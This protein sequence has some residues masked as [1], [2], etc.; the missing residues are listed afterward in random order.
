M[1]EEE[2]K[3]EDE[4]LSEWEQMAENDE[5]AAPEGEAAAEEGAAER[6]LDQDEIDSLLGGS[7]GDSGPV[8]GIK[9][10]VDTNVVNYEKL[11]MLEVIFDK[12]ERYL[13]TSLRHFT[14]DNVDVTITSMTSVRFG[15]YLNSVPL[16]AGLLVVKAHGLDDYI[17]MVY[18]SKLI[19]AVVDILL[20]GRK[21]RPARVEGRN[22]TTIERRIMDNLS[23]VVLKDLSQAFT[24]VSP[25]KFTPERMEVNPRFAV[26]TRDGNAAILITVKVTLEEREGLMHFCLP[27]AT[28]EPIRD[29]L[30]QQFMGEKFG[31][32][33][34]WENHL[35]EELY[36]TTVDVSA[37]MGEMT[38][39]LS[40]VLEWRLGDTIQLNAREDSPVRLECGTVTKMIGKM[41]KLHDHK[42]VQILRTISDVNNEQKS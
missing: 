16:P 8:T 30:L 12:F 13:S 29:Q 14:A 42:A 26:I 2:Q 9:A 32:D 7:G 3:T 4:L 24:P 38:V 34:I 33:N 23:E 11:P 17:L 28:L 25:V 31:Q 35:A 22:F 40:D 1:A 39:Q 19:Y 36:H 20:G 21:S 27:Y 10:L 41:G 15:D 37:V 6:I 18:E 5:E